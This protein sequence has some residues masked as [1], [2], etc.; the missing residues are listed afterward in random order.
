M[1]ATLV[2]DRNAV[3][4][5]VIEAETVGVVRQAIELQTG[6]TVQIS[7]AETEVV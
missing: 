7:V 2:I 1:E 6:L 5:P 3:M 4:P